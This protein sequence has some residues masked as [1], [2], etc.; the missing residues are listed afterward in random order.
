MAFAVIIP[1]VVVIVVVWDVQLAREKAVR[2]RVAGR[3]VSVVQDEFAASE[4]WLCRCLSNWCN[5]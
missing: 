3:A 4:Q 2:F 5:R 1:I